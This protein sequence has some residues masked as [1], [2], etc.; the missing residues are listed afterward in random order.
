M[1]EPDRRLY[2][3]FQVVQIGCFRGDEGIKHEL[4]AEAEAGDE[5]VE[6][7]FTVDRCS[8][9]DILDESFLFLAG[10]LIREEVLVIGEN[11]HIVV[12]LSLPSY[13]LQP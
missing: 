11:L 7:G 9:I 10:E 1:A 13:T 12:L 3:V 2:F 6:G 5:A 4:G 8:C